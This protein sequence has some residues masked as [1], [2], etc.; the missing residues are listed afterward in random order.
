[1]RLGHDE[2]AQVSAKSKVMAA[3]KPKQTLLLDRD[4]RQAIGRGNSAANAIGTPRRLPDA[5]DGFQQVGDR[6]AICRGGG[7]D[8][9]GNSAAVRLRRGI[10]KHCD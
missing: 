4:K 10:R 9:H 3:D 2:L 6:I 8:L 1:M 5:P 7:P